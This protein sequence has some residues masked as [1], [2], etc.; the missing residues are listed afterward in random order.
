LRQTAGLRLR[1]LG[2]GV[3]SSAYST[4]GAGQGRACG[5]ATTKKDAKRV[6]AKREEVRRERGCRCGGIFPSLL[7]L[8]RD[9]PILRL[10]NE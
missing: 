7:L 5:R 2:I 6:V 8:S 4:R 10:Q 9:L 3:P 1:F